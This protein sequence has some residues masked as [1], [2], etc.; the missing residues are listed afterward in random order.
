MTTG[1]LIAFTIIGLWATSLGFLISLDLSKISIFYTLLALLW[2]TFL[3]TGLFITAHDAMHGVACPRNTKINNLIGEVTLLIYALFS[4]KE[5]LKNHWLHHHYPASSLDPDF[6]N[7]KQ[8]NVLFWYFSFFKTYFSWKQLLGLTFMFNAIVYT[9]HVPE[10]SLILFWVIPSILSSIQLFCFGTFLPH[11][12]PVGGYTN[13]H[14]AQSNS[15]PV[16]W[17][18]IT[19]YHFGYHLEHHEY[20]HVPWWQLPIVHQRLQQQ[21]L[22]RYS[23]TKI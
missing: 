10:A 3:Y 8:E 12:E 17:S 11:R 21:D 2:Q 22:P 13:L 20:P 7:K 16:F 5:L 14:C 18:F 9:F 6:Y 23:S 19:C 4:Y 1:V 15:L